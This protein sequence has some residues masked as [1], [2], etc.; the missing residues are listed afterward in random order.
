MRL[1]LAPHSCTRRSSWAEIRC[2]FAGGAWTVC[3]VAMFA[4][5][6]L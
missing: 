5:L 3:E 6:G 2:Y 1:L 4:N